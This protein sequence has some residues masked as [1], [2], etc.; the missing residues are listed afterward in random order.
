MKAGRVTVDERQVLL[1]RDRGGALAFP[2]EEPAELV[3]GELE[4]LVADFFGEAAFMVPADNERAT[5]IVHV[6][7]EHAH[8]WCWLSRW[9][10]VEADAA[11]EGEGWPPKAPTGE[12]F[13]QAARFDEAA[14]RYARK[15]AELAG[16]EDLTVEAGAL[17]A[18]AIDRFSGPEAWRQA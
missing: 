7:S 10:K 1:E 12:D 18:R 3:E 17:W 11:V 15:A 8:V 4:R 16:V 14:D 9:A 13:D 6:P 5:Y 2:F